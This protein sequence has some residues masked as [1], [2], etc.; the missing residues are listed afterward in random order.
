MTDAPGGGSG[1]ILR[2]AWNKAG[3]LLCTACLFWAINPI[4]GRAVRDLIS[5][6]ALSFGRWLVAAMIVTAF[7]WPHLRRDWPTV[8]RNWKILVVLAL[9]GIGLFST[10]VY[11]GL[12]YT[13]AINNLM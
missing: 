1:N 10:L 12:N 3:L 13:T 6:V 2:W 11:W 9:L 8:V 7:A 4:V 5:P